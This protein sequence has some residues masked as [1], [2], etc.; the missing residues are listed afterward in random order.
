MTLPRGAKFVLR[1][2]FLNNLDSLCSHK[3]KITLCVTTGRVSPSCDKLAAFNLPRMANSKGNLLKVEDVTN[4]NLRKTTN[5][6]VSVA[7]IGILPYREV[8]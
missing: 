2:E 8:S 4:F 5:L 3:Q 6:I 1:N 7:G